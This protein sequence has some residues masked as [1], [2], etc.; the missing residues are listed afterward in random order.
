M[1]LGTRGYVLK[2]NAVGDIIDCLRSVAAG[3]PFISPAISHLL[4]R[5]T[6][7]ARGLAVQ[8]P[9]L[10]RLTA[11]ER[12]ILNAIARGKTTKEIATELGISPKTVEN[13]RVNIAGKLGVHGNNA[14]LKYALENRDSI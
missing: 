1:D 12:R 11:S 9:G 14:L 5:R 7:R 6:A 8:T 3:R 13:H 2:E 4:L 10:H